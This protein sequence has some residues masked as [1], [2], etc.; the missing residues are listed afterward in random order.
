MFA[1]GIADA[2]DAGHVDRVAVD[3]AMAP[4]DD[5]DLTEPGH[6]RKLKI[7]TVVAYL[8]H[9]ERAVGQGQALD[10]RDGHYVAGIQTVLERRHPNEPGV[11]A[12]V[13]DRSRH[14]GEGVGVCAGV[15]DIGVLVAH[16]RDVEDASLLEE[17]AGAG[18]IGARELGVLQ[19]ESVGIDAHDLE[20]TFH[21]RRARAIHD[22]FD[23]EQADDVTGR[24]AVA[25]R[26]DPDLTAPAVRGDIANL[27]RLAH[28]ILAE[29]AAA[30]AP[31]GAEHIKIGQ[32]ATG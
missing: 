29:G 22:A 32:R 27:D 26:R 1:E 31:R 16:L 28:G 15:G 10:A 5:D 19:K 4:R 3:Q 20:N 14:P 13:F 2:A 25:Q 23:A 18:H 6:A 21:R 24:Q 17:R 7:E 8:G 30:L 11:R 9:R 12:E